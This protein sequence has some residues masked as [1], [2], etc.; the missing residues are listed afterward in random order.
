MA[1]PDLG[2]EIP[3]HSPSMAGSS[4]RELGEEG[5]VAKTRCPSLLLQRCRA[6]PHQ[7][8]PAPSHKPA[9]LLITRVACCSGCLLR[10]CWCTLSGSHVRAHTPTRAHTH[11][12]VGAAGAWPSAAWGTHKPMEQGGTGTHGGCRGG[13]GT[14]GLDQVFKARYLQVFV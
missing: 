10:G 2:R 1:A 3:R 14:G 5:D 6:P 8:L 9:G 13:A 11:P 4:G 7:T 12:M